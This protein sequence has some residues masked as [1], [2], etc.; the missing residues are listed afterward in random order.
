MNHT[1]AAPSARCS[2]CT[3]LRWQAST[4]QLSP[5][6]AT[7]RTRDETSLHG[8]LYQC[9]LDAMP[10][11]A[12]DQKQRLD[13]AARNIRQDQRNNAASRMSHAKNCLKVLSASDALLFHN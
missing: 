5:R 9:L 8:C 12:A 2:L 13:N 6:T 3:V 11:N 7:K 1:T 10:L 4:A